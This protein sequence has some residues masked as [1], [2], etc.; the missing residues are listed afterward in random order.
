MKKRSGVDITYTFAGTIVMSA[1]E[2]AFQLSGKNANASRK[3]RYEGFKSFV[4][5]KR[6]LKL[7]SEYSIGNGSLVKRIP[8]VILKKR[9]L[10]LLFLATT[11]LHV[12]GYKF[13]R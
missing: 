13:K 10:H 12:V 9:W 2:M 6:V 5:D 8:F 1:V 3:Q 11:M 7:I 4:E